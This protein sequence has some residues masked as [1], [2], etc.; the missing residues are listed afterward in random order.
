MCIENEREKQ[1]TDVGKPY[2]DHAIYCCFGHRS[3]RR[4]E[5][6]SANV[7][8]QGHFPELRATAENTQNTRPYSCTLAMRYGTKSNANERTPARL[9]C[10]T[11]RVQHRGF[12]TSCRMEAVSIPKSFQKSHPGYVPNQHATEKNCCTLA[13][14]YGTQSNAY[15]M[16]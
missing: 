1:E 7:E 9:S 14:S 2:H 12:Q 8:A 11:F 15:E 3:A 5:K 4:K 13:M 16:N 6:A 10:C